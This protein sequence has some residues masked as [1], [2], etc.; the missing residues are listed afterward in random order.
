MYPEN[1]EGT[2]VIVGSMNMGYI[3]DTA[4]N[5]TYNLFRPKREPILLGHTGHSDRLNLWL[6]PCMA[7]T[8]FDKTDKSALSG[9]QEA[10]WR[11]YHIYSPTSPDISFVSSRVSSVI[12]ISF[13]SWYSS[14]PTDLSHGLFHLQPDVWRAGRRQKNHRTMRL[15]TPF[16]PANHVSL[17]I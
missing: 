17:C 3:S 12:L 5:R 10:L 4:R 7:W 1:P 6:C 15:W 14:F 8:C 11:V 13:W 9:F 2:Q 16:I